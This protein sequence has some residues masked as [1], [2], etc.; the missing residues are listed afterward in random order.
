ML[1]RSY[2]QKRNKFSLG[3]LLGSVDVEKRGLTSGIKGT[4]DA[5]LGSLSKARI[6]KL[7][8]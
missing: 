4:F 2:Y 1:L 8:L 3:E 6:V 5:L 7:R